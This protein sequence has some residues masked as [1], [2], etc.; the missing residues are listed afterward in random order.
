[1][2]KSIVI[3]SDG[4]G[5]TSGKGVSNVYRLVRLLALQDPTR[6][7]VIYDQGIGTSRTGL[8]EAKALSQSPEGKALRVLPGPLL[9][10]VSFLIRPLES[11]LGIGLYRNVK[12]LYRALVDHYDEQDTVYLFGFSRGAFTVRAL[13]GLIHRCGLVKKGSAWFGLLFWKIWWLRY[14]PMTFDCAEMKNW[15]DRR[16]QRPCPIHFLGVWDTVKSYGGLRPIM[17]PHLRHNPIVRHVR[18]AIALDEKRGWFGVTTWGRLDS[19]RDKAM[20]RLAPHEREAIERQDIL[21]VWFRGCHSDIGGGDKEEV[22]AI[23]ARQWMLSEARRVDI[24]AREEAERDRLSTRLSELALNGDGRDFLANPLSMRVPKNPLD[25]PSDG[26]PQ[27]HESLSR[28]WSFVDLI[29]RLE[30]DNSD[31]WPRRRR[32]KK[33]ELH[34]FR[35]PELLV[36]QGTVMV[37]ESVDDLPFGR[38]ACVVGTHVESSL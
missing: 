7:L 33:G 29:P 20:T 19:D 9:G 13:A 21:E 10:P 4:T 25:T 27:I 36:R 17:L 15:R 3:C 18:H 31:V 6:Q 12:Q 1:M 26:V 32:Q 22:T 11:A 37:H 34:A 2:A 24:R 5:N 38:T 30:I 8:R 23:I 35:S 14:K 28:F 16:G